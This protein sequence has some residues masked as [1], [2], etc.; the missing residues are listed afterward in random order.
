MNIR[1]WTAAPGELAIDEPYDEQCAD[2]GE[3]IGACLCASGFEGDVERLEAAAR[4]FRGDAAELA[5]ALG[6]IRVLEDGL[7]RVLNARDLEHTQQIARDVLF[8]VE[9]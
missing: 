1:A 6:R 3:A 4:K 8:G 9:F 5:G 2:C 7:R